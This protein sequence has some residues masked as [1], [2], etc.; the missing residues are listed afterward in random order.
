MWCHGEDGLETYIPCASKDAAM[1]LAEQ[2][3]HMFHK[4]KRQRYGVLPR[5]DVCETIGKG[6]ALHY[7]Y[8][9]LGGGRG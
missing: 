9:A 7:S 5:V 6:K 4:D 8:N 1:E 2:H 3:S